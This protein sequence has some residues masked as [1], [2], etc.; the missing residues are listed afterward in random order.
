M[1]TFNLEIRNGKQQ[2]EGELNSVKEFIAIVNTQKAEQMCSLIRLPSGNLYSSN[3]NPDLNSEEYLWRNISRKN[4]M[5]V[6]NMQP[7]KLEK[8]ISNRKLKFFIFIY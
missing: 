3:L 7:N 8:Y 2:Q 5:H 6:E 1:S 4:Q